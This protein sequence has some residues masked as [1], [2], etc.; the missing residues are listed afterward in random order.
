MQNPT[1]C[2][3]FLYYQN[4]KYPLPNCMAQRLPDGW[5]HYSTAH[6]IAHV[7]KMAAG[8][9]KLGLAEGDK[10]AIVG[11]NSPQW[12]MADMA[13]QLMGGISVPLY[14]TLS[15]DEYKYILEH[16]EVKHVF[17]GTEDLLQRI[18]GAS[19]LDKKNFTCFVELDNERHWLHLEDNVEPADIE[20]VKAIAE[21]VKPSDLL[22]I[23]YTSGTTGTPKGVMLTHDNIV[24]NTIAV[25][26]RCPIER[27][28]SRAVSFLPLSH[29]YERTGSH[30]FL[31][32]GAGIFFSDDIERLSSDIAEVKPHTFNTV[33]R[34][35]EKIYAKIMDKGMA[36]PLPLKVLFKWAVDHGKQNKL[37]LPKGESK[38]WQLKLADKLIFK[39][40]REALG[41]NI[42]FISVGA[43][44]INPQLVRIFWAA[45]IP[46]CEGYGLTETSPVISASFTDEHLIMPG[47]AG[48]PL[49]N[50]QVKIADDGEVLAKGPNVMKGYYKNE[51]LTSEV[52]KDGWFHTGDIGTLE[53]DGYLRITDRKKELFKTSG[54]KYIAP[55]YIE[56]KIKSIRFVEQAMVLGE[57]RKFPCALIVPNQEQ[58][59]LWAQ[60]QALSYKGYESLL[61]EP[62]VQQ[63]F[64]N[65]VDEMNRDLGRWEQIKQFRLLPLQWTIEAG[66]LTP[67]LKLKRRNILANYGKLIEEIYQEG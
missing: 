6:V 67:T 32:L 5:H 37:P 60:Q 17:A 4:E 47:A 22:T 59:E 40:W 26:D 35:I 52:I 12:F 11:P 20:Q 3:D 50:V 18:K 13:I 9:R 28:K 51:Q 43:A 30:L 31:Y 39:K 64:R 45:G 8:L 57:S 42:K 48:K 24:N 63:H 19:D 56:N 10:I 15:A 16:A 7:E 36:L 53:A 38:S 41:G 65:K 27:G 14:P 62:Q 54:G 1:R 61:H 49:G 29:I 46:I 21:H 25:S 23:I 55:Q 58:L 66:E 33:P 44:A 2:F 34:L